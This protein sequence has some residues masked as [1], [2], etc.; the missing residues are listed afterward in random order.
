V[1]LEAVP[2]RRLAAR[3]SRG[4]RVVDQHAAPGGAVGGDRRHHRVR[5]GQVGLGHARPVLEGDHGLAQRLDRRRRLHV[6]SERLTEPAERPGM[7]L[8]DARLVDAQF[9]ADLLHRHL[10][11]V[12]E[13]DDPALARR[14]RFNRRADAVFHF[15]ALVGGVGP[16]GFHRHEHRRQLRF[17]DVVG[18]RQRRGLFDGGDAHDHLAEALLVGA[19]RGGQVGQRR[20]VTERDAQPLARGFELAAHAAHAARPGVLAQR[21]DH[22]AAD[23]SLGEGLELDAARLFE[24]PCRVDQAEDAVLHQVAE[25]DGVRHRG[26]DAARQRLDE[27]KARFHAGVDG[28]GQLFG[29]HG[30]RAP[31]AAIRGGRSRPLAAP[32]PVPRTPGAGRESMCR[33]WHLT[34]GYAITYTTRGAAVCSFWND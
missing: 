10:A 20:L 31:I 24:P 14:Q 1:A 19:H 9:G 16:L 18:A 6:G 4:A 3:G 12:I 22:R 5:L 15:L 21:V 27:R 29:G 26:G 23:A 17:V 34:Y 32:M 13:R 28:L 7:E 25:V 8:R 2:A 33:G 30:N 11:V